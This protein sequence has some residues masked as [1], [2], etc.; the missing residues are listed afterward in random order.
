MLCYGY[1]LYY[2]LVA[3]F[4]KDKPLP[5]PAPNR[6]AVL[7]SARNEEAVIGNLIKSLVEQTY[8][9]SLYEIIL[10]AD[11]CTDRTAEV[12]KEAGA[13]VY[14]RENKEEKGTWRTNC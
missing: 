4:K 10:V 8:D 13:T 3:Y 2:I 6:L 1:Q 14:V 5:E 7:I 11:N 12:A 9:K